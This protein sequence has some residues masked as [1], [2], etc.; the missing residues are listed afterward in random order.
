MDRYVTIG[1]HAS[2]HTVADEG[3]AVRDIVSV[4]GRRLGLPVTSL[5]AESFGPLGRILWRGPICVQHDH[6]RD[7]RLDAH[8]PLLADL[9]NIEL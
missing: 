9:E 3:E 8:H 2:F 5:L 4:I 7:P 6:P 1:I